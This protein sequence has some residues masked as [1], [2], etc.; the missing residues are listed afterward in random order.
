MTSSVQVFELFV[1]EADKAA[2][3]AAAAEYPKLPINKVSCQWL[4]VL[5]EGWAS[6]LKGA[7]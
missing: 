7:C 4:Q 5:A 2:R 1:A 6:P 3:T